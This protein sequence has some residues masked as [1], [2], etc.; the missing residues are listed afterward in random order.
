[1]G[2]LSSSGCSVR[3][4]FLLLFFAQFQTNA[5]YIRKSSF[6][7][8]CSF[9]RFSFPLRF[10]LPFVVSFPGP[11]LRASSLSR[12][13]ALALFRLTGCHGIGLLPSRSYKS[14]PRVIMYGYLV[15]TS[16]SSL[17]LYKLWTS[18][19]AISWSLELIRDASVA[20]SEVVWGNNK[21]TFTLM[22]PIS[23]GTESTDGCAA[24]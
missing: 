11:G 14:I 4:Q 16:K 2:R 6:K 13:I 17:L 23:L 15:T 22:L 12:S 24:R 8:R 19:V 20:L 7:T 21:G 18:A 1:M 9:R 3:F 5:F 10:P